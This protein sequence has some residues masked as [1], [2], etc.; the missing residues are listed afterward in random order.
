MIL[1]QR[2][3]RVYF[4]NMEGSMDH[5]DPIE[6]LLDRLEEEGRMM[7]HAVN[8]WTRSDKRV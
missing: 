3:D 1:P 2:H 4:K 6:I 5:C 7:M 8:V